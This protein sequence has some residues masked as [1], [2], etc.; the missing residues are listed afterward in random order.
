[1]RSEPIFCRCKHCGNIVGVIQDS[2]VKMVCCGEEMEILKANT[3]DGAKEKHVPVISVSGTTV[4]VKVGS[5]PHPMVP[6][7]YIQWIYLETEKGGQR[8]ILNPGDKPEAIFA[9]M[10]DDTPLAAYEYCNLHGLWKADL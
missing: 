3:T 10:P 6:E 1:M 8:H 5:E 7:H 2:G 9:V 4:T